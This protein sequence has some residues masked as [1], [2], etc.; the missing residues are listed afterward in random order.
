MLTIQDDDGDVF[1]RASKK[2]G[3]ES[4]I[5]SLDS[6]N[7]KQVTRLVKNPAS[8]T[9]GTENF[10]C[11]FCSQLKLPVCLVMLRIVVRHVE[12]LKLSK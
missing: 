6:K 4:T 5:M 7:E 9:S 2:P 1:L 8:D 3:A 11:S 12:K 10:H